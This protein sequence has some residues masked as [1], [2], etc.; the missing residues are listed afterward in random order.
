MTGVGVESYLPAEPRPVSAL[1]GVAGAE[2]SV[3]LVGLE[4]VGDEA[5]HVLTASGL[6]LVHVVNEVD[7]VRALTD[8]TIQV[9]LADVRRGP[10]LIRAIRAQ[11]E[12]EAAHIVVCAP[13][14]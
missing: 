7:G 10:A 14:D 1:K 2:A 4:D 5:W 9:V 6:R 3:L 11:S 12:L 8:Q 13:A